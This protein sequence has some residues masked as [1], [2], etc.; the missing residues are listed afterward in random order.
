MVD[1]QNRVSQTKCLSSPVT[2]SGVLLAKLGRTLMKVAKRRPR[3]SLA[4]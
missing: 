1:F 2:A 3:R 4:G